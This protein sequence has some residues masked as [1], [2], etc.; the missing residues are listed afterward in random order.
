MALTP[1]QAQKR[2][3]AKLKQLDQI[4]KQQK[5]TDQAIK[6]LYAKCDEL[7][8]AYA[9][10]VAQLSQRIVEQAATIA[11]LAQP[12]PRLSPPLF[13]QLK[14]RCHPDAGGSH[15]LLVYIGSLEP[16]LVD[17]SLS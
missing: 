14:I 8:A 3:R 11:F 7:N 5:A 13:Q 9:S 12:I 6:E 16:W 2:Y 10:E 4:E 1:A 15:E 17:P